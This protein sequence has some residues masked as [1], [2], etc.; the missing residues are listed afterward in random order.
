MRCS[1][2]NEY[3]WLGEAD[4]LMW[5]R[6][7]RR[8]LLQQNGLTRFADFMTCEG[9]EVVNLHAWREVRRM[10]L[11]G[12]DARRTVFLKRFGPIHLK[13][14]LKDLLRFRRVRTRALIEFEMLCAFK[15]AGITVPETLACGERHVLGRDRASFIMVECLGAGRALDEVLADLPDAR[16]RR[17]LITSLAGF[18]RR[19]HDAGLSHK[20]LFAKHLFVEEQPDGSWTT[21]VIDLQQAGESRS[22]SSRLRGRD[23]AALMVSLL[24]ETTTPRERWTFLLRYL[25]K[26]TLS[27]KDLHFVRRGVL[28]HARKLSRR[29]AYGAWQPILEQTK[30]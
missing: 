29:N 14:A 18:V 27:R 9:G 19:M 30:A 8:V 3:E 20:G 16:R 6:S 1:V 10:E 17:R 24:P 25:D 7:D 5:V 22:V 15:R 26:S 11:D 4:T 2:G 28:P 13:D 12:D 23:L 21:A